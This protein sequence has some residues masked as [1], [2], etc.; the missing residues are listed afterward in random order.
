MPRVLVLLNR[1]A[2]CRFAEPLLQSKPK[3]FPQ[4][5]HLL[6]VIVDV[7]F[8]LRLVT[9]VIEQI[10]DGVPHGRGARR[11]SPEDRWDWRKRIRPG[12]SGPLRRAMTRRRR[13]R[14]SLR[15]HSSAAPEG[16]DEN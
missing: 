6:A 9:G 10:E 16:R 8:A 5:F 12:C 13:L 1:F 11:R 7:V 14:A 3:T 2:R 15:A 4:R